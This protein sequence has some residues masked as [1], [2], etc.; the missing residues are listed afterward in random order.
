MATSS[1]SSSLPYSKT[2][3]VR[4]KGSYIEFT[5]E[6]T[7]RQVKVGHRYLV[8]EYQYASLQVPEHTN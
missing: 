2:G 3:A 4:P 7:L 6:R 1:C 8:N 5:D